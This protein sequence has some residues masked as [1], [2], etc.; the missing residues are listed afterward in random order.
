MTLSIDTTNSVSTAAPSTLAFP[1]M[2]QHTRQHDKA[3]EPKTEHPTK[4]VSE[5]DIQRI[6]KEI[7]A[8]LQTMHATELNF[9]VDK[10]TE[11]VVVKIINSQTHEVIRQIP[12]EDALRIASRINKL[13][14]LL[15]DGNA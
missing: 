5:E 7:N 9:S 8:A 14:G 11:K 12:A 3:T 13:L 2:T 1:P 10:E 15:I 6:V 4:K